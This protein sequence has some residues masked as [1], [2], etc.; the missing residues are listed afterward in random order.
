MPSFSRLAYDYSQHETWWKWNARA[1]AVISEISQAVKRFVAS[2]ITAVWQLELLLLFKNSKKPL[3]ALE[4]SKLLYLSADVLQPAIKRFSDARILAQSTD[5]A[6]RFY[7]SP[8]GEELK[9]TIDELERTYAQKRVAVINMI[10]GG[11]MQSFAD[12]FKFTRG[13]EKE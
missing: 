4:A 8:D 10:F 11:T 1:E 9:S 13:E 6:T 3:S 2:H 12:A 7:Y 5:D